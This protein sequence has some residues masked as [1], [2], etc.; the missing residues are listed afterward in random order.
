MVFV[1]LGIEVK[2]LVGIFNGVSGLV[3]IVRVKL[4]FIDLYWQV[5]V[6][7]IIL[8]VVGYSVFIYCYEGSLEISGEIIVIGKLVVLNDGDVFD[9][10]SSEVGKVILVVVVLI[11]EFVVQYGFFVMN[12]QVEIYQVII[13]YQ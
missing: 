12:I 11:G 5:E 2:V 3:N 7:V 9:V 8:V 13:D 6:L 4:L 10:I 1:G